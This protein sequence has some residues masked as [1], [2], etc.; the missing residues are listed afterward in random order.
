MVIVFVLGDQAVEEP[1]Q[2]DGEDAV[3]AVLG[4]GG[5]SAYAATCVSSG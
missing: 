3:F 2:S 4:V 1:F 5:A